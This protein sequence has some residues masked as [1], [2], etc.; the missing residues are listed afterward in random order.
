MKY[1]IAYLSFVL[2]FGLLTSLVI[3]KLVLDCK[4]VSS[5]G[6]YLKPI[7]GHLQNNQ[8]DAAWNQANN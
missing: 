5:H 8:V 4:Q 6:I 1:I 7:V 3:N 2:I